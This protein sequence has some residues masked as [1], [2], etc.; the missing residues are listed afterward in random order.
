MSQF[1]LVLLVRLGKVYAITDS[2]K[3]A[4][5]FKDRNFTIITSSHWLKE[6]VASSSL[7]GNFNIHVLPNP[8]DHKL[9]C[10]GDNEQIQTTM[11]LDP[12]KK[13][14]LFGAQNIRNIMKGFIYFQKAL[15]LLYD[16]LEDRESVEV[17]LFGKS[18]SKALTP[19]KTHDFSVIRSVKILIGLYNSAYMTVVPSIQDNLP[20]TVMESL[21]CGTPVVGFRAGGIPEMIDHKVNGYLAKSRSEQDLAKGMRWILENK[22]YER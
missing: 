22:D 14:I 3:L 10:P 1:D 19:F 20:S 8:I 16:E 2:E 13:I 21:S 5:I 6:C 18:T 11:G 4:E 15:L 12:K 17:V 7:L 9:Y